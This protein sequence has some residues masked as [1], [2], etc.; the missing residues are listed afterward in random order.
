M[1][2]DRLSRRERSRRRRGRAFA[3]AFA[4][5]L[6]VLVVVGGAG[7]FVAV[8][9]GPRVTDVQVDPAGAIAASGSRVILTTTQALHDV[10]AAQVTV[11]P[12][13]PF[14]VDTSGRNVGVR[15]GLPLRDDTDYTVTVHDVAG[16]G[17]GPAATLTTTFRTPPLQ[18]YILQ[19]GDGEDTIYRTDLTGTAAEAVFTHP[20]IED[21]RA[22]ASHLVISVDEDDGDGTAGLIVTGPAGEDPHDLPLPGVGFVSNLQ[23]ADR[24]ETIGYTFSDA[25]L[26]ADG[27][28]ESVLYTTSVAEGAADGPPTPVGL[29]G[30][31]SRVAEWRFVPDTDS[32]LV[33]TFDGRLLLSGAD[34]AGAAPLGTA[35]G[36]DGIARGS[37]LAV[38][39]RLEGMRVIDLTD[40]SEEPLG[41]PATPLGS[42]G[43]VTPVPGEDAGTVRTYAQLTD[44]GGLT[45]TVVAF[46]RADGEST[47]LLDARATD[48]VLQTCV[49]ASGR[50]AAVLVAPDA[51]TNPYDRYHLPLPQRVET[52]VVD[53]ET[54][55]EVVLDGFALSWCQ[56]PAA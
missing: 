30:D 9:Q 12:A 44:G 3:G 48:S 38:V 20:H 28:Q 53:I 36:I 15:F 47:V 14:T 2:T 46:V 52:H 13:A 40:G 23:S 6:G 39:E 5:V 18:P 50:Y 49:S 29:A 8:G 10:D 41:E 42:L 19:R 22:T 54:G 51:A 55:D 7:A 35:L 25:D 1:S 16:R 56:V 34:G 31:D 27:G 37:S 21:F 17:A 32:I 43:D 45:S 26:G 33:L 24:G 4:I 11:E